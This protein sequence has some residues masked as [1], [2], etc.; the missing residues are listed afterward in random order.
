MR[1]CRAT[2]LG[3]L[4]LAGCGVYSFLNR[5]TFVSVW[6]PSL[7]SAV[8]VQRWVHDPAFARR[9]LYFADFAR[10]G[11]SLDWLA[12]G[13]FPAICRFP[14]CYR[15]GD[16]QGFLD[17][18]KRLIQDTLIVLTTM[19]LITLFLF[20]VDIVW[21]KVLSNPWVPILQTEQ[22]TKSQE[23]KQQEW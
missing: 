22:S 2:I 19:L 13:Q 7:G 1:V 14:D 18:A 8:A 17:D 15:S 23:L 9:G 3:F 10:W 4:I 20:V 12:V 6:P 5:N 21:F 11:L 16:E